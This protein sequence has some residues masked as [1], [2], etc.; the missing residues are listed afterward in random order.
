MANFCFQNHSSLGE[1]RLHAV[2]PVTG[3]SLW[4][5]CFLILTDSSDYISILG[6]YVKY[7]RCA[8]KS[9]RVSQVDV[10]F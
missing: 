3:S 4:G 6:S 8:L 9:E 2:H 7:W 10:Q 1:S 5:G